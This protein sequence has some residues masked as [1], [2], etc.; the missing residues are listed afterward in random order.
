MT[1]PELQ[2]MVDD[3]I[4]YTNWDIDTLFALRAGDTPEGFAERVDRDFQQFQQ[5]IADLDDDDKATFERGL[6]AFL[7]AFE[8]LDLR[9]HQYL[10]Y[11]FSLMGVGDDSEAVR[12]ATNTSANLRFHRA[13]SVQML[14]GRMRRLDDSVF[15]TLLTCPELKHATHYVGKLRQDA[16]YRMSEPEEA[17]A[18]E[19]KRSGSA[20]W[21]RLFEQINSAMTF[22]M[23]AGSAGTKNIGITE[24]YSVLSSP[25]PENRQEAFWSSTKAREGQ[26][27]PLAASLNGLA[28]ARM[29]LW[30]KRGYSEFLDAPMRQADVKRET[31]EQMM[32]VIASNR[33]LPQE[34]LR[35]K[36]RILGFERLGIYDRSAALPLPEASPMPLDGAINLIEGAFADVHPPMAEF[37]RMAFRNR[38][39]ETEPGEG[40]YT[41]GFCTAFPLSG[42]SG[43]FASYRGNFNDVSTLAHEM[44]HA[45]HGQVLYRSR[46]WAQQASATPCETAALVG[47]TMLRNHVLAQTH[48]NKGRRALVLGIQLDTVVN[49][50]LRIPRDYEFEIELYRERAQGDLSIERL[51]ALMAEGYQKWFGDSLA[52]DRQQS[53]GMRSDGMDRMGWASKP[54]FFMEGATF[55]NF[56]YAMGYLLAAGISQRFELEGSSFQA[57]Y[58]HYLAL[59]GRLSV[60]DAVLEGLGIDLTTPEFWQQT[61]DGLGGYLQD[62]HSMSA[63]LE[64]SASGKCQ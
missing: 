19:L 18:I 60:E 21:S 28:G 55:Y 54:H 52:G 62:M 20:G 26:Q 15:E 49:Y 24:L 58:D 35:L 59:T 64:S 2:M 31:V 3:A 12:V 8:E 61:I 32:A 63:A 48:N 51:K 46:Y 38:W 29:V 13:L 42:K 1:K 33:Q 17:L 36:A 44:G 40:K 25:D 30:K 22:E 53:N 7:L 9:F 45:W 6:T 47:E 14:R 56:P 41:M 4:G 57:D 34:W 37:I 16:S 50:L 11:A 39:V 43:I 5:R 10:S 23:G 27:I